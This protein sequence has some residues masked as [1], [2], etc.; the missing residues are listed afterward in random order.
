MFQEKEVVK[1]IGLNRALLS[2]RGDYSP[3]Y[4]IKEVI[5]MKIFDFFKGCLIT[6]L[7]MGLLGLILFGLLIAAIF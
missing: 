4:E 7:V 5:V 3:Y 2:F 6:M 1:D